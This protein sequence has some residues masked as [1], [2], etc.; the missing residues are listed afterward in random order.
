MGCYWQV[1][2][3]QTK[4]SEHGSCTFLPLALYETETWLLGV[5]LAHFILNIVK[6]NTGK[7]C[8]IFI[9]QG[10]LYC[11]LLKQYYTSQQYPIRL[12]C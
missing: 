6:F 3:A 7:K 12:Y 4:V 8:N 11:F 5:R 10:I 9:A 1:A 2:K